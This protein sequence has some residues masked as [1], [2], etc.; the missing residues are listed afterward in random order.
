MRDVVTLLSLLVL[1]LGL[2]YSNWYSVLLKK[3]MAGGKT[4]PVIVGEGPTRI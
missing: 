2:K 1:G 3:G 4:T